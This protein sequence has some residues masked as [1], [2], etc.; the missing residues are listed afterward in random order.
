MTGAD[1]ITTW[2]LL[3]RFHRSTT[4][5][6][7]ENLRASFGH[8]LDEYDVLHQIDAHGAPIRMGDL[9]DN[10]LIANSSCHRIVGRLV[11]A[12]FVERHHGQQ[13]ARVVLVTLSAEGRRLRRRMAATHTRDIQR[14]VGSRLEPTELT[15][16]DTALHQLIEP[17]PG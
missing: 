14:M 12:G 10:L 13:D 7:D 8:T 11:E 15:A 17:A 4:R 5:A 1:I 16:L 3:V 9:A 6:M 2:E